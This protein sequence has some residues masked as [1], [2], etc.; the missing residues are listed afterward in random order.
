MTK[1]K[2]MR[3]ELKHVTWVAIGIQLLVAII[4]AGKMMVMD[5]LPLKFLL[6]YVVLIGLFN[7]LTYFSSRKKVF[8]ISM[9]ILSLLVTAGLLYAVSAVNKVDSTIREVTTGADLK[10]TEMVIMV[11]DDSPVEEA[12]DLQGCAVAYRGA[13]DYEA[14]KS[15]MTEIFE[16]VGGDINYV[17]MSGIL[18]MVDALYAN[19]V[20]A[21]IINEAYIDV[22]TDMEGYET[23]EEDTR[24]IHTSEV[25]SYIEM[26]FGRE[27]E[28]D[29][30]EE[31]FV[32]Y[33][34]GID[35]FGAVTATSRSDVN[36]LAAVNP[37]TGEIQLINTPR[38]YY[39]ELPISN[40][41]KDKLTHAGIYGV[42]NSI[43]TLEN[44]YDVEIDYFVRM[45]FSGFEQIIDALGG[46]DV[47]SEYEFTVDP[48]KTYTVG[49]NHLNGIEALAFARERHAFAAGDVQRGI[50]Q[51]AVIKATIA[52][53]SS[54]ELLYN[55][56]SV[57]DSVS[58]SFQTNMS[59]Q[60][61][62]DLVKM[63]LK[64]NP[65]WNIE[66]YS[67]TGTGGKEA[68]YSTPNSKSY[69]MY[70]NEEDIETAKNLLAEVLEEK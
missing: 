41:A 26:D 61:I 66:T 62:Y 36:I 40:G 13:T 67:V 39:V 8:G 47:Y 46:I 25:T 9:T 15:V 6:L 58:E 35:T 45:N 17:E 33:I 57:L 7:V 43:G 69:I 12:G 16:S 52:K 19:E 51:M 18:E 21:L 53:L 49:M 50:N 22:I 70:P 3:V 64:D 60:E 56:S 1:K 34:S 14:A 59:S 48:I 65:S 20:Q 42:D 28:H 68:C 23:Y 54:T 24:I 31:P 63:Q 55:Y 5:I 38:D 11:L 37:K 27:E 30:T 2:K 10:V 32:V 4:L 29:I 44:L